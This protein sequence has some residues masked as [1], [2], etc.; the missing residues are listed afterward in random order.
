[1]ITNFNNFLNESR[2][3]LDITLQSLYDNIS[4]WDMNDGTNYILIMD[5]MWYPVN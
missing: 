4:S 5:T 3:D 1:M 2:N